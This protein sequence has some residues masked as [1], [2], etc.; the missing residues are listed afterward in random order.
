MVLVTEALDDGR[1]TPC[2]LAPFAAPLAIFLAGG[3]LRT[4]AAF[5]TPPTLVAGLQPP[6]GA[7][8]KNPPVLVLLLWGKELPN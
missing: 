3:F 4:A 7:H 5:L 2:D 8:E 1:A 6:L